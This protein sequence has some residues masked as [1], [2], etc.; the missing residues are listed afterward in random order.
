[1]IRR[2]P[3]STRTDTRFPYTTLFRSE[4]DE[5]DVASQQVGEE[6]HRVAEGLHQELRDELDR[7]HEEVEGEGQAGD[8]Q[9][10]LVVAERAVLLDAR[11]VVDHVGDERQDQRQR[12][13]RRGG[14]L[15]HR[16]DLED[17]AESSEE[18]TSELQSIM[19]TS[20]A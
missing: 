10:V 1:M 7:H 8:D 6:T 14:H 11:A 3:G 18:H 12:D 4:G 13:A 17:V 15:D 2:A 20:Y 16:D 9:R 5:E 19:S